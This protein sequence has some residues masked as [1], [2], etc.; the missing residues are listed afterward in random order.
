VTQSTMNHL[1]SDPHRQPGTSTGVRMVRTSGSGPARQARPVRFP[2]SNVHIQHPI[3]TSTF[4]HPY[5][6]VHIPTSTCR[7]P[8]STRWGPKD[9]NTVTHMRALPSRACAQAQIQQWSRGGA[10]ATKRIG[11][12]CTTRVKWARTLDV[13]NDSPPEYLCVSEA[14]AHRGIKQARCNN[15]SQKR[16]KTNQISNIK[17]K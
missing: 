9:D 10:R 1:P 11:K 4:Q 6:S 7:R 3:S 14:F 13:S 16:I 17:T 8:Q 15:D 12:S 5:F 2:R